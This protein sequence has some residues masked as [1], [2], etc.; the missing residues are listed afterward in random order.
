[1]P[2]K[3]ATRTRRGAETPDIA[4]RI[5]A[6]DR[7]DQRSAFDEIRAACRPVAMGHPRL[8]RF[9]A[10]DRGDAAD[11]LVAEYAAEL[12]HDKSRLQAAAVKGLGLLR[13]DFR[14]FVY[15]A[16][17]IASEESAWSPYAWLRLKLKGVMTGSAQFKAASKTYPVYVLREPVTLE[18]G[19]P[20]TVLEILPELPPLP[21]KLV[22]QREGQHPPIA[23]EESLAD[24]A[25]AALA[26]ARGPLTLADLTWL[27][28]HTLHPHPDEEFA[29]LAGRP[30]GPDAEAGADH[31]PGRFLVAR[32][33]RPDA[34]VELRRWEAVVDVHASQ[35]VA[36]LPRAVRDTMEA[37]LPPEARSTR[38]GGPYEVLLAD[39]DAAD[40]LLP[41][42][43]VAAESGLD[44]NKVAALRRE[45]TEIFRQHC[46]RHGLSASQRRS[47]QVAV[48]DILRGG[49]FSSPQEEKL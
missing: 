14:R 36:G 17:P 48:A 28:W 47:L 8:R 6:S 26:L 35:L 41:T 18:E 38:S 25:Y 42:R 16:G 22:P 32:S 27:C 20:R 49:S 45:F 39:P 11:E 2:R 33:R 4:R 43:A 40:R 24:Q 15:K 44:K 12:I 34:E 46:D 31:K 30:A 13:E 23:S 1:M 21:S 29:G 7:A 19:S 3:A 9:S 5:R 10:R 37:S